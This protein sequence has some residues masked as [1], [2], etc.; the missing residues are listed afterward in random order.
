MRVLWRG[1]MVPTCLVACVALAGGIAQVH[2]EEPPP[3][4]ES[5]P[6]EP[7]DPAVPAEPVPSAD[8]TATEPAPPVVPTGLAVTGGSFRSG[9]VDWDDLPGAT[10]YSVQLAQ[11]AAMDGAEEFPAAQS[12][13]TMFGLAPDHDYFVRVRGLDAAGQPYGDWSPVVTART[14]PAPEAP[15][16]PPVMVAS[17]NIRCANCYTGQ[18]QEE[19]WSARRD[20][21]VAQIV[22]RRPDVIGLQEASQARLKGTTTPQFIDLRDR[23]QAAGA[24]YELTNTNPYNCKDTS[25]PKGC[26]P[27]DQGASQG[28][29]IAYNSET[30]DLVAQGSKLLPSCTGCNNRYMAWTIVEQ[31]ATGKSF[32]VASVHTQFMARYAALRHDEIRVMMDEVTARNPDNLPVF[33]VGDFNST[34]YQAPTNAP[35]DEVIARGLSDPLGHTP[36]SPAVSEQGTAETRIRANYNSH[37]NFL[38]KVAKFADWEN[39]SNLDYILTT[40]MRILLWETVLDVDDQDRIVGVIPSDHNMVLVKAVLP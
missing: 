16:E 23:L 13:A 4:V 24:A 11:S 26:V 28:T 27:T 40:P 29:R 3:S 22:A 19:P 15:S 34:R 8:P 33:V 14:M 21:V 31:K 7:A 35:Y 39:G 10:T 2:A 38:R 20:A 18:N 9:T 37:N 12:T 1:L 32:F 17:F 25:T 30:V 36:Q 5:V 6:A